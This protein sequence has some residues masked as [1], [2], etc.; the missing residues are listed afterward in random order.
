MK[1]LIP[2]GCGVF[3]SRVTRCQ[4]R[5]GRVYRIGGGGKLRGRS[6][7]PGSVQVPRYA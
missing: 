5:A 1:I 3:S 4:G 6:S 7:P 2:N